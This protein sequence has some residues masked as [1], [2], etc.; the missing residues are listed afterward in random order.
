MSGYNAAAPLAKKEGSG[1]HNLQHRYRDC[2]VH[3]AA[4]EE[5]QKYL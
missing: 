5:V 2:L 3:V 1:I 4:C